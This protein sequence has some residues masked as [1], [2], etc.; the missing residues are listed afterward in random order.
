VKATVL[1]AVLGAVFALTPAPVSAQNGDWDSGVSHYNQKQ[2]R[3]A[4]VDFQK[5]AEATP[6]F[7]NTYFYLGMS[8][9]FLKEYNK[10]INDLNRYVDLTEKGKKKPEPGARAALGRAYFLTGD[11]TKAATAL[12]IV[13]Q[14][15]TDDP[16]N[17]FYL[18]AAYQKLKDN[19][20]A[21]DALTAGLRLHPKD[22]TMLDQLTRLLL[23]QALAS[24]TPADFQ[25]AIARGEQLR[26][27]RDDAESALLLGSA[28]LASGDFAKASVHYGRV[29]Q[30]K[31]DD[32]A[33]WFNYGLSLSRSKQYAKAET[34]LAKATKLLPDNAAAWAELGFVEE[35]LKSY[36]KA[37]D[38]YAKAHQLNPDPTLQEALDRV[39]PLVK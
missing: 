23:A 37:L 30:A 27:T 19:A 1:A 39:K 21:I 5:V 18:A 13:T 11:H 26:L 25:A 38:A 24:K 17:F 6:D 33:S 32:G 8:H 28:Y 15:H 36:A 20:K 7:A 9:F 34:A 14:T 29:V 2:F 3:Q 16:V 4:I 10:A 12:A 35:S 22:A 31:P